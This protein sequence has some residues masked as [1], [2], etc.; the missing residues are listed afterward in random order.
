MASGR[1]FFEVV[2]FFRVKHATLIHVVT[3]VADVRE[4]PSGVPKRLEEA[5][6]RVVRQRLPVGDYIVG[7]GAVVERKTVLGLH[8]SL[9]EGRFWR[10]MGHLR[11]V[12]WPYL[13]VD[14]V[15][16]AAGPVDAAA[17]RGLWIAASDLGIVVLR[18]ND[19]IDSARWLRHVAKRRQNPRHRDRPMYAQR[20]GRARPNPAEEALSAAPGLSVKTARALLSRYGSLAAVLG[21]EPAEWQLIPGVGPQKAASLASMVH[22]EWHPDHTTSHSDVN[23]NG[24]PRNGRLS[25]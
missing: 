8:K 11:R 24:N 7:P 10:Q 12:A 4:L 23:R 2:T 20:F 5:G 14:G 19:P 3:V 15:D 1:A 13:L 17:L 6:V 9:I 16:L 21:A 25:T 22:D 18:S